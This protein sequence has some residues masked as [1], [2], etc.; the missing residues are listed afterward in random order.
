[1]Q[2]KIRNNADTLNVPLIAYLRFR[3]LSAGDWVDP[4]CRHGNC[5]AYLSNGE[6]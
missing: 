3:R 5:A 4:V 1:M 2:I 6:R